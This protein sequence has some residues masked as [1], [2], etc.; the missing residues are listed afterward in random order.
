MNSAILNRL[1]EGPDLVLARLPSGTE[2]TIRIVGAYRK[3]RDFPV[4]I[5]KTSFAEEGQ[6]RLRREHDALMFLDLW[7]RPLGIPSVI[8]FQDSLSE[9]CLIQT[10]AEGFPLQVDL[11][12][13]RWLSRVVTVSEWIDAFQASVLPPDQLSS[14]AIIEQAV[15]K[16]Q[17]VADCDDTVQQLIRILR[18]ECPSQ[19][20][21]VTATHGDFWC[22]NVFLGPHGVNV[23]DWDE[24]RTGLPLE[25]FFTFALSCAPNILK[26]AEAFEYTFFSSSPTATYIRKKILELGLTSAEARLNFYLFVANRIAWKDFAPEWQ[27][28]LKWLDERRY[29]SP[30]CTS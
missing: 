4:W 27:A 10:G 1:R 11:R 2:E 20:L 6:Q 25:D 8:C 19:G 9:S 18:E 15:K 5:A 26:A 7:S 16:L 30:A 23:I 28:V 13:K 24:L 14:A 17:E 29:P 21:H 12:R 22:G 3:N